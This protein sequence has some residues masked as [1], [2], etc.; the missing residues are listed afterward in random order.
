[1]WKAFTAVSSQ[2]Y[3][4]VATDAGNKARR[5]EIILNCILFV[6]IFLLAS[7][8]NLIY[9]IEY[10]SG[11]VTI[12]P[13]KEQNIDGKLNGDVFLISEADYMHLP[14]GETI[15]LPKRIHK[16]LNKLY[17]CEQNKCDNSCINMNLGPVQRV[18]VWC[19]YPN[20]YDNILFDSI[21]DLII[22]ARINFAGSKI[23][24]QLE[25]DLDYIWYNTSIHQIVS[26]MP[27]Q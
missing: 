13:K 10:I 14:P 12:T 18:P 24:G 23:P 9:R 11:Q 16:T 2:K 6:V 3:L 25:D 19:E 15:S 4:L 17:Y 1:M 21:E 7:F 20:F 22:Q 27:G 8:N 5:Y 26:A